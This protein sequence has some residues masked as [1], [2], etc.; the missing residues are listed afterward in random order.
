[1]IYDNIGSFLFDY[2][3]DIY[4]NLKDRRIGNFQVIFQLLISFLIISLVIIPNEMYLER[5]ES[6][7]NVYLK[8][9]GTTY[10][11]LNNKLYMWDDA[12]S[13]NPNVAVN[14]IFLPTRVKIT[15]NQVRG[16]CPTLDLPC[17]EDSQ[18]VE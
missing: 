17:I 5:E 1:M 16:E 12:N 6:E 2:H 4:T 9:L 10:G 7:S 11:N 15:Y 14:S 18:C 3:T 13:E 8:T